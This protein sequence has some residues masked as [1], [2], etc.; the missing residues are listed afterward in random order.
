[1]YILS[2]QYK[3]KD[4]IHTTK[5]T[6]E[7]GKIG[8]VL[9]LKQIAGNWVTQVV[10]LRKF[11]DGEFWAVTN[12]PIRKRTIVIGKLECI[13]TAQFTALSSRGIFQQTP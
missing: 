9:G 12:S 3:V 10:L 11:L 1:M 13:K 5:L 6:V 2:A 8:I 7:F 4:S